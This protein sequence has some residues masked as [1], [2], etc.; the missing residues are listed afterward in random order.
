MSK[1][2]VGWLCVGLL[3]AAPVAWAG[4]APGEVTLDALKKQLKELRE[5]VN[6]VRYARDTRRERIRRSP[7]LAELR[8]PRDKASEVYQN[9]KR[10][11]PA[12]VAAVEAESEVRRAYEKLVRE[13]VAASDEAKPFREELDSIN[14]KMEALRKAER[15]LRTKLD[16]IR[17]T[18]EQRD[19]A[20]LKAARQ[21]LDEARK[22]VRVAYEG[23]ELSALRKVRNE[24]RDAFEAKARELMEAD[25]TLVELIKEREEL[26]VQERE[27]EKKIREREA[28]RKLEK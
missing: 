8:A 21:T 2:V 19:D 6:K 18:V 9:K 12:Y 26:R 1:A 20:E 3:C 7:E 28:L 23:E 27:L 15:E 17:R 4:E 13:K 22:A 5:R 10:T 24:T 11:D 16:E 25:D 14:E